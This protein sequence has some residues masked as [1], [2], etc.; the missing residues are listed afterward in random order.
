MTSN[1]VKLYTLVRNQTN[2]AGALSSVSDEKSLAEWNVFF[3]GNYKHIIS[4]LYYENKKLQGLYADC[5]KES[6]HYK[7]VATR[8]EIKNPQ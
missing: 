1:R 5:Y 8:I 7:L 2:A 3:K 4:L 6:C